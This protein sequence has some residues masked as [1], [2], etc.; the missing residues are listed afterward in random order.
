[1]TQVAV[2][3]KRF[4]TKV[5]ESRDPTY[6]QGV[7]GVQAFNVIKERNRMSAAFARQVKPAIKQ[8][9]QGNINDYN[10]YIMSERPVIRRLSEAPSGAASHA[11]PQ[12][13]QI[14]QQIRATAAYHH[15]Q[16]AF[17]INTKA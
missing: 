15:A 8:L 10:F 1:M 3:D 4:L 2:Y 14:L 11:A 9:F 17:S 5:E 6:D 12:V 7:Q 16:K 13:I